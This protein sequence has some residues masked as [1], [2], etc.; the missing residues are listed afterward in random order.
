MHESQVIREA[1]K[2]YKHA[3]ETLYPGRIR[4]AAQMFLAEGPCQEKY[5]TTIPG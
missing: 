4:I 2:G 3:I 5:N 1:G